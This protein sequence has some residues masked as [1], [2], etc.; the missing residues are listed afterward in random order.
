MGGA[1]P[2]PPPGT[3]ATLNLNQA[4]DSWRTDIYDYVPIPD[5]APAPS[6]DW[7]QQ[8]VQFVDSNRNAGKT[9]YVHCAGGKSR[10]GLVTVAY[11]MFQ[12]GWPRDIALGFVRSRR[13][14]T[15]PNPA[16]MDLLTQYEQLL[17]ASGKGPGGGGHP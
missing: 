1:V 4:E 2:Q 11:V 7:L 16:F 3:V 5:A 8:R 15:N 6:L 9:T 17:G 13:P 14:Q 10:S 12:F